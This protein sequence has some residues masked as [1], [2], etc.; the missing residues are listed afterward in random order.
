M[1]LA[2]GDFA[3]ASAF[4]FEFLIVFDINKTMISSTNQVSF[5]RKKIN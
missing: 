4:A 1:N 3:A 5:Q 2:S